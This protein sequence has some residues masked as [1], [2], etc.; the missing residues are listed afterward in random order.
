MVLKSGVENQIS[1][2]ELCPLNILYYKTEDVYGQENASELWGCRQG[3][4]SEGIHVTLDQKFILNG[5]N[6][7]IHLPRFHLRFLLAQSTQRF[8][9]RNLIILSIRFFYPS[10]EDHIPVCLVGSP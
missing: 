7:L 5:L 9:S 4:G 6:M 1:S 2:K 8:W 10:D 3:L